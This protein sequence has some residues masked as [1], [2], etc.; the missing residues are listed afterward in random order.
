[1]YSQGVKYLKMLLLTALIPFLPTLNT[2]ERRSLFMKSMDG[3]GG[4]NPVLG[5]LLEGALSWQATS[6]EDSA[7]VTVEDARV[8]IV[9]GVAFLVDRGPG[10]RLGVTC[11][12]SIK[13]LTPLYCNHRLK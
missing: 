8:F 5:K 12:H 3:E 1:M 10:L 2:D 6:P 11:S 4:S 9:V 7:L 13:V